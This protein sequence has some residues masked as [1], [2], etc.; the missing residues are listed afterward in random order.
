ML[1]THLIIA[2]VCVAAKIDHQRPND[3]IAPQK[4]NG[5]NSMLIPGQSMCVTKCLTQNTAFKMTPCDQS[6]AGC[7]C[8]FSNFNGLWAGCVAHNCAGT[9]VAEV[10]TAAAIKCRQLN[11]NPFSLTKKMWASIHV[12]AW[13]GN[14]PYKRSLFTVSTLDE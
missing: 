1:A 11:R 6:D 12:A 14:R 2:I 9:E 5:F 7:L 3:V 8:G 10:I 4:N 13:K